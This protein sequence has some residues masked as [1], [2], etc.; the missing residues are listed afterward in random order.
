MAVHKAFRNVEN[1]L[2]GT[3]KYR[4]YRTPAAVIYRGTSAVS[5]VNALHFV[6]SRE[7]SF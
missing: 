3:V 5:D 2:A 1:A 4:K 6:H 7:A